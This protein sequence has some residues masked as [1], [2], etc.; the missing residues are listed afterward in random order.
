[1][2]LQLSFLFFTSSNILIFSS[3]V[4][5]HLLSENSKY[6]KGI[7]GTSVI[8]CDEIMSVMDIEST[9]MT[10]TIATNVT[11]NIHTKK[12]RYKIDCY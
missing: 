12:E 2:T 9:K 6:L 3:N 10:N 7:A 8:T 5:H 1:M 4:R 11:I